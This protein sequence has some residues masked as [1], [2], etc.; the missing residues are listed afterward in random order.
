MDEPKT[1]SED[2]V[3]QLRSEA[4][5]YRT[6][7]RE[8]NSQ[9]QNFQALEAQMTQLRVENELIRR[10]INADPG[11]VKLT[12]DQTPAEAVD[13]FLE[14][15]PQFLPNQNSS[16]QDTHLSPQP[17]EIPQALPNAPGKANVPGPSAKGVLFGRTIDEVKNDAVARSHL[18]D[19]YR[20]LLGRDDKPTDN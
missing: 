5:G 14:K 3:K 9:L 16:G 20:G 15:Y 8:L 6:E 17:K 12:K 1:F 4:A 19:V 7:A 13:K 18:T 11:F 10:G 2:Y